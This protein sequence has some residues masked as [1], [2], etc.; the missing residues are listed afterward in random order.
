MK[1]IYSLLLLVVFLLMVPNIVHA[2]SAMTDQQIMDFYVKA[3]SDGRSVAQIVTQLM[4]RGVTVERIRRI[5]RNYESQQKKEV[6]GAENISGISGKTVE[7]LRKGK[8]VESPQKNREFPQRESDKTNRKGL[9]PYEQEQMEDKDFRDM[10]RELE[11]LMP[12]DSLR[13]F[14]IREKKEDLK[15]K[16]FGR[17]IFNNNKLTF[18]P[19]MN[20]ATPSDYRLG[21]G[22]AVYVD[23]WGAS[24]KQYTSTVSPEGVINLEGFGPVQ[25]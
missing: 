20:I 25:D 18:E 15:T 13:R 23:V 10:S 16:V 22:D 4:E 5:R 19:E 21:P 12:E 7:R 24:Q 3:K 9:S 17:D 8:K 14:D 11:F 1:R 2:Q 6:V